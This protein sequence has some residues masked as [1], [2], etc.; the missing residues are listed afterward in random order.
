MGGGGDGAGSI[1]NKQHGKARVYDAGTGH[2]NPTRA[3]DPGLVY[4]LGVHDHVGYS[5]TMVKVDAPKSLTLL[6]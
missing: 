5:A 1:L 4:D 3:Y 2:V 6:L